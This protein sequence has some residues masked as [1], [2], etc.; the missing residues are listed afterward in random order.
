MQ[1]LFNLIQPYLVFL[2]PPLVGAFI[3][4]LTNRIA[5]KMLFRPLKPW[6]IFGIRLPMTPGVIPSKRHELAE[7]MGQMVGD[8]LLTSQEVGKAIKTDAFQEHL[9]GIIEK[10]VGAILDKDLGPLPTL[11][12][13][14]FSNYFDIALTTVK[15]QINE[16]VISYI[17]SEGFEQTVSAEIK[18]GIDALLDQEI[19]AVLQSDERERVY[20]FL[21]G[22]IKKFVDSDSIGLWVETSLKTKVYGFLQQGKTLADI[23]PDTSQ[24]ILHKIALSQTPLFLEKLADIT[25]EPLVQDKIVEG[26]KSGVGQF[27]TTLGP[28]AAM[29]SNF[30]T[31]D[32]VDEKVREFLHENQENI[33]NG[34]LGDDIQDRI[35]IVFEERIQH[36]VNIPL[37]NLLPADCETN[38]EAFCSQLSGQIVTTLRDEKTVSSIMTLIEN[39][40]EEYTETNPSIGEMLGDFL[41]H[42]KVANLRDWLAGEIILLFRT[43]S[44]QRTIE[45][46]LSGL[47]GKLMEKPIGKLSNLLPAGVRDGMYVSL[48]NLSSQ[49]LESEVPGLVQSLNIQNIVTKKIDSL[50]LLKLEKLLLSIMEEQFKYIN[51]FGAL[52]G[53]II[54]C[55]NLIIIYWL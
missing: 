47:V 31:M 33:K 50:D 3:G 10:K 32:M 24:E 51:L 18:K 27:I 8:H 4:Y 15:Y 9:L 30:L 16:N 2:V 46:M 25:S 5:I 21:Y 52:L 55:F 42:D 34:I 38:I 43:K 49:I 17:N 44:S 14:K 28:M 35:K 37:A 6:R 54:G 19:N 39:N 22:Q 12:P 7:N 23:L 20:D 48:R 29:V 36:F 40:L 1:E 45:N 41:G 11:V 13:K 26:V 53:F